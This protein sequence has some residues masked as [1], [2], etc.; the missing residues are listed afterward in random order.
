MDVAEALALLMSP[1]GR[2]DPYPAYERLRGYGPVVQAG[3]DTYVVTGYAEADEILRDSR[4]RVL[5]DELRD[6]LLPQWRDSPARSSIARS[7]LET[8][9]PDH[10]RMRR[11]AAGAFTPRRIAALRDVV[12]SQADA[13]RCC[14][15]TPGPP[16]CCAGIRT[17]PRR[18]S[19][20]CSA[21]TRPCS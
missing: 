20:S 7:M 1:E 14:W 6:R 19:T 12:A 11:L 8:N 16:T 4:F 18:T 15:R 3:P 21:S 9:P 5:D 17:T 10:G 2:V 13:W